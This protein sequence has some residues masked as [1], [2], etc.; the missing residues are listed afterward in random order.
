VPLLYSDGGLRRLFRATKTKLEH[1]VMNLKLSKWIAICAVVLLVIA[2][3]V[4]GLEEKSSKT[5]FIA[6]EWGTFT[7]ISAGD[8][9]VLAWQSQNGTGDLPSFVY[10]SAVNHSGLL[11]KARIMSRVRMET[12]VVYFYADKP[13][14]LSVTATLPKG[15]MTE[16]Y[17]QA[18]FTG[19]SLSW[20]K[21]ELLP[22]LE[23]L[24]ADRSG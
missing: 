15:C 19:Q 18:S 11:Q 16:W 13:Q 14:T 17:P 7:T 24:L 12:P 10:S 20:P 2:G 3:T 6:H 4:I 8:G 22:G 23:T 5:T 9:A 21:V 1:L